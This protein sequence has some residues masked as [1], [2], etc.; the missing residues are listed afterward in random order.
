MDRLAEQFSQAARGETRQD[1]VTGRP[2]RANLAVNTWKSGDQMTLWS[3][4]DEAPRKFSQKSFVQRRE[5]M[6]GDG[7]QL[8]LDV[9]HWNRVNKTEDPITMPM[10]FTDDI[11]ERLLSTLGEDDKAT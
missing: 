10:D 8:T 1:A 5:Q 11:E 6:V 9:T 3:D 2:Y 7:F 4:I